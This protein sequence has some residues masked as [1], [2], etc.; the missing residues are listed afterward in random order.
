L[1]SANSGYASVQLIGLA[2]T[3]HIDVQADQI[4][5]VDRAEPLNLISLCLKAIAI[6]GL[7]VGRNS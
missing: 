1:D 5:P 7:P 4:Q 3:H 2:T 6:L